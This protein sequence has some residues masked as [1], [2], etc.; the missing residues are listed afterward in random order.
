[1]R[2]SKKRYRKIFVDIA[3][4]LLRPQQKQLGRNKGQQ[5]ENIRDSDFFFITQS[6]RRSGLPSTK[7]GMRMSI[8]NW[9]G[10][11]RSA[12]IVL[13]FGMAV[14]V[15][16]PLAQT[17][18]GST[19][20]QLVDALHTAFGDFHVRAVHAKGV[21]LEGAFTP[22]P[23]AKTLSKAALFAGPSSI[24]VRFSDFTGIPTI[25]DTSPLASPRGL[26]IKFQLKDGSEADVVS[27]SFNGFPV[28]TS[29]EFRELLLTLAKSGPD[30]PKPTPLDTYLQT[31]PIAKTF[32]TTQKPAPVSYA[33]LAY[34]GVNAFK[35]TDASGK[36]LYVRYRFL[37]KAGE[38][39]VPAA[40][41]QAKGANYLIDEVQAR[42]GKGPIE[43]EWFAQ[44][45][46][47]GDRIDD[48]SM[49]WPESRKLVKLGALSI[50]RVASDQG[51]L[52]KTTIFLPSNV[53]A[54]I[55]PADPMIDFRSAAYPISFGNR[56]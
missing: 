27:H 9:L 44:I 52:D 8:C 39:F 4:T 50:T 42:A 12:V 14:E 5:L 20:E 32:L 41:L 10:Y 33:T 29:D 23:E 21:I 53:P 26:A 22:S 13:L 1:M 25:P 48:P 18:N 24:R 15:P 19:P 34:F 30:V 37:P 2:P 56:Q 7:K 40:E 11:S 51:A 28:A 54:G 3:A 31:H 38:Q 16:R 36:A 49:A 46:G 6:Q 43:F 55:E 35:F 47:D 17:A 45:S